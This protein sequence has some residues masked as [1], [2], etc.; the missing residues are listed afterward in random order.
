MYSEKGILTQN[1]M[2]LLLNYL[3]H[4]GEPKTQSHG[5]QDLE[6]EECLIDPKMIQGTPR[7]LQKDWVCK[8][9]EAGKL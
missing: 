9:L 6:Q 2:S 4:S 8:T 5:M 3:L 7:K 1:E